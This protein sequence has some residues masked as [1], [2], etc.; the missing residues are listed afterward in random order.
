MRIPGRPAVTDADDLLGLGF[1]KITREVV[2][3]FG[4]GNLLHC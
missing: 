3:N 1:A 4:K 2:L